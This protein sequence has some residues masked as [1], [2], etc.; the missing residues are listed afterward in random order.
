MNIIDKTISMNIIKWKMENFHYT[1]INTGSHIN[2]IQV[3]NLQV[4]IIIEIIYINV[5]LNL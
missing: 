3:V 4:I 1:L 2:N 5:I